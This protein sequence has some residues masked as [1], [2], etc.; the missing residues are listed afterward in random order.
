MLTITDK[1]REMLEQFIS[2][3]M[4]EKTLLFELKLLAEVRKASNMICN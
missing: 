3:E 2:Q 4:V 1:A